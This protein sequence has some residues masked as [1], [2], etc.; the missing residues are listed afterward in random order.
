MKRLL[1]SAATGI[2]G[3][4]R[5]GRVHSAYMAAKIR[6]GRYRLDEIDLLPSLVAQGDTVID[7]GASYGV[8][9]YHLARLVGSRG[10]VI[11]YE[12]EPR[13]NEALRRVLRW[14]R[15]AGRVEV[16]ES[17]VSSEPGMAA[18]AIPRTAD[19]KLDWGSSTLID[20]GQTADPRT[21]TV[22]TVRVTRL[23]DDVPAATAVA[24]LKIDVEGADLEVLRGG[25][26][27]IERC[28]PA[29]L[30]EV[31]PRLLA[32]RGQTGADIERFLERLGYVTF[33]Y[34]RT[35]HQLKPVAAGGFNGDLVA[36]HGD[37]LDAIAAF[38]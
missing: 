20:P 27:L 21:T 19:G 6:T 38:A 16:R 7:V 3:D 23:D 18:I 17:A 34:E 25:E 2:L 35:A 31:A 29:L 36:V 32:E 30:I 14:L 37:R 10:R 9:S 5:S 33:R 12:V 11:A 1:R 22:K 26:C 8:Y 13:T 4:W 28:R 15:V 24:L